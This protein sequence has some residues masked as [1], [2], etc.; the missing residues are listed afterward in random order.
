[1][2]DFRNIEGIHKRRGELAQKGFSV[3]QIA[4]IEGVKKNTIRTW[5]IK[6]GFKVEHQTTQSLLT[7]EVLKAA[8]ESGKT[9]AE[10]AVDFGFTVTDKVA[11]KR[12]R[13]GLPENKTLRREFW[14]GK[15][16][17]DSAVVDSY[18]DEETGH[19]V[20][21]YEPAYAELSDFM[22]GW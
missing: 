13:L 4:K 3:E 12:N 17:T 22:K 20:Y 1:M 8:V 5:L 21:V 18:I 6:H 2:A 14:K 19:M 11:E 10:I 7:D 9:D 15:K 16:K